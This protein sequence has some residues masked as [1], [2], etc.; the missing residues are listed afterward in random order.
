VA[1]AG[2]AGIDTSHV[3]IGAHRVP[4]ATPTQGVDT[5]M[6]Y[7]GTHRAPEPTRRCSP[8]FAV[9]A[10]AFATAF[11]VAMPTPAYA[12]PVESHTSTARSVYP[13]RGEGLIAL[14]ARVCGTSAT[15][16]NVA[17]ANRVYGPA[18][19]IY[20]G[21]AYTVAC[22]RPAST[23]A[24]RSTASRSSAWVHP[25]PGSTCISGWG[26]PR[27]GHLHKGLDFPKPSGTPIRAAHAGSVKTVTYSGGAG[28][29]VMLNHGTYQTVYMHMRTRSFLRVGQSVRAGQ[30]IGYVGRTGDAT[31]PHLHFEIHRGAW[32]PFNPAPFLR[33][34]GVRVGC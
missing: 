20:Y 19:V 8:L 2:V 5:R 6:S 21:R 23:T 24:S 7:T 9:V 17:T 31:G 29:Y 3:V 4:A 16:R 13:H 22:T 18:F 14:T 34:R 1:S 11:A 26:A 32:H 27:N 10:L 25:L 28:W 15:W 12:Q 30:T 33:A